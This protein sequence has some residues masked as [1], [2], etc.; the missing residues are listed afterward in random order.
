MYSVYYLLKN[1]REKTL[2]KV[3]MAGHSGHFDKN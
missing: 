2:D 1:G 3:I